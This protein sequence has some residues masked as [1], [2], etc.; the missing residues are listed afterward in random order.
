MNSFTEMILSLCKH[1]QDDDDIIYD[2]VS[3]TTEEINA[4][5]ARYVLDV[6]QGSLLYQTLN[7]EEWYIALGKT[8]TGQPRLFSGETLID[9]RVIFVPPPLA[10]DLSQDSLRDFDARYFLRYSKARKAVM[11]YDVLLGDL[12]AVG[13]A[14]TYLLKNAGDYLW[15]C[16]NDLRSQYESS[17]NIRSRK[18]IHQ[19]RLVYHRALS[20]VSKVLKLKEK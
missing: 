10:K 14:K 9:F 8:K 19:M 15:D 7:R 3:S 4:R 17:N 1:E 18:R 13:E 5:L 16:L 20:R 6:Q 11:A 2:I 12:C